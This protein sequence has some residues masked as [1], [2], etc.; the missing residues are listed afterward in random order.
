LTATIAGLDLP[1]LA[2]GALVVGALTDVL[3]GA[4]ARRGR[5]VTKLGAY[6]DGEADLALAMALTLA[7]VRRGALPAGACWLPAAR[8][9][10][11]V[12]VAFGTAFA[13]GRP[14]ALEHTLLGRLC[15]VAQ[16]GL[17]GCSLAPR[18]WRPRDSV[19]R[20]LLSITI[21]LSVA[22]GVAQAMRMLR[23]GRQAVRVAAPAAE[24]ARRRPDSMRPPA[25]AARVEGCRRSWRP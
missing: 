3:D 14:P 10:L 1:D 24:L 23:P 19:R 6:A 17:L 2:P 20:V 4:L 18:R 8:Y 11:P 15:G 22:S 7:S 16:V 5:G 13:R 12:G 21:V 25:P 9:A